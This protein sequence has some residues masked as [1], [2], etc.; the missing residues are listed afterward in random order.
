MRL[1][2]YACDLMTIVGEGEV[3]EK[4]EGEVEGEVGVVATPPMLGV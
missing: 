4:V 2:T 1:T 3:E